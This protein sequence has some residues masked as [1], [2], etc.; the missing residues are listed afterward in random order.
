MDDEFKIKSSINNEDAIDKGSSILLMSKDAQS[1]IGI[2]AL[3]DRKFHKFNSEISQEF[4]N[5]RMSVDEHLSDML[6]VPC[7]LS[8]E[9][10][11]FRV[12][13]ISKHLE[14]NLYIT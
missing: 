12:N 5:M 14:T 11:I 6:V 2:D 8:K 7:S 3:Y 13:K 10:S 1:I 9:M 4:V